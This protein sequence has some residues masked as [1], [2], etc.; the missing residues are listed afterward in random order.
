MF[1]F[2]RDFLNILFIDPQGQRMLMG[3]AGLMVV[4]FLVI[5]KVTKIRI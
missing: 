4:G 2:N 1:A 5:R 3:A